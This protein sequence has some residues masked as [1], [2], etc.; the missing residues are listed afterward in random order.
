MVDLYIFSTF[1]LLPLEFSSA[2]S[3]VIDVGMPDVVIVLKII[4]VERPI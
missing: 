4:R 1:C 3:L 2:T